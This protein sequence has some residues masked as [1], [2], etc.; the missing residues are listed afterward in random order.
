M[1]VKV[2]DRVAWAGQRGTVVHTGVWN[3][4]MRMWLVSVQFDHG[5]RV[6]VEE[7]KLEQLIE[8]HS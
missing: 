5:V 7:E 8:V 4:V 2:G 6:N 3:V 1:R